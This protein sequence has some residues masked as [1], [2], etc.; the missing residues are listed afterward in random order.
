MILK[1]I[2]IYRRTPTPKGW[3]SRKLTISEEVLK[4]IIERPSKQAQTQLVFIYNNEAYSLAEIK[5]ILAIEDKP[6]KYR[7]HSKE[8]KQQAI[9]LKEKGFSYS[10]IADRTGIPR[11]SLNYLFKK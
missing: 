2:D 4:K 8:S 10:E 11:G 6:S 7:K 9:K 3:K 1:D 5:E